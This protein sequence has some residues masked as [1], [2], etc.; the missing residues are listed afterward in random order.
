MK[1]RNRNARRREPP[2]AGESEREREKTSIRGHRPL[3]KSRHAHARARAIA[4]FMD[5][6]KASDAQLD[7]YSPLRYAGVVFPGG[8]RARNYRAQLGP[9][10]VHVV[11]DFSLSPSLSL[12]RAR[13]RRIIA[14]IICRLESAKLRG[15]IY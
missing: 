8:D 4:F 10:G 5:R 7:E 9:R 15:F 14:P 2:E 11:V 3:K 1:Y 6:V 12:S 13:A